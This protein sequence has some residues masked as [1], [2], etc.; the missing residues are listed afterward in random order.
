VLNRAGASAAVRD[1]TLAATILERWGIPSPRSLL[2]AEPAQLAAEAARGQLVLKPPRG[3]HGAGVTVLEDPRDLPPR[4]AYPEGVFAQEYLS[5]ARTDL[6]LFAIGDSVFGV[7]KT[8]ATDSFIRSGEPVRISPELEAL[9]RRCGQ[10]FGLELYGLDIAEPEEGTPSVLDVNY[11]PGY[12]GVPDAARL[13]ADH[14][15][16]AAR[17]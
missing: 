4:E 1:K 14:I 5:R 11:F 15:G 9:A 8:F 17:R 3:Y 7:R 10:A 12:R 2:A 16:N 13:L 6:K